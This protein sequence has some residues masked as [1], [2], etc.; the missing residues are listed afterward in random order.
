LEELLDPDW[1]QVVLHKNLG[2]NSNHEAAPRHVGFR[3]VVAK[4]DED[5]STNRL[6]SCHPQ[7][8]LPER[9][10]ELVP[11]LQAL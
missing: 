7:S 4:V 5:I 1:T 8:T 3:E 11:E 9:A 2:K 6:L 10:G